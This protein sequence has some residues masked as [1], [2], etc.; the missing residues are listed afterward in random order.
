MNQ[1]SAMASSDLLIRVGLRSKAARRKTK[2]F[3]GEEREGRLL[4]FQ[5]LEEKNR[6]E[7]E[8][9]RQRIFFPSVPA[10]LINSSLTEISHLT[11]Y[12]P[13]HW[14][15]DLGPL[16]KPSTRTWANL[17]VQLVGP[18]PVARVGIVSRFLIVPISIHLVLII[19][20]FRKDIYL[21]IN[22]SR[23]NFSSK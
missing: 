5:I 18:T 23:I 6:N 20:I 15:T 13:F 7:V 21:K 12:L 8:E 9:E 4:G 11:H 3:I 1:G 17:V 16:F 14:L 2:I 10:K 22:N 19:S